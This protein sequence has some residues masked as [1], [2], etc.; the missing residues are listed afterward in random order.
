MHRAEKES[1]CQGPDELKEK[2][3]EGTPKQIG[4]CHGVKTKHPCVPRRP[5]KKQP[6]TDK[7]ADFDLR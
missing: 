4:K 2:L 5:K 3:E 7:I 6:F 1:G